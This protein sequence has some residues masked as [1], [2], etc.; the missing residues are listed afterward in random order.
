VAQTGARNAATKLVEDASAGDGK[1][2]TS[3]YKVTIGGDSTQYDVKYKGKTY[4][5]L[6]TDENGNYVKDENGAYVSGGEERAASDLLTDVMG[7]DMWDGSQ[8]KFDLT[9]TQSVM[10]G[11]EKMAEAR[12]KM[13]ST[14]TAE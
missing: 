9:S 6:V 13:E 8:I 2:T 10:E 3:Q 5:T 11:Y 4:G 1:T 12:K 7:K 14:F